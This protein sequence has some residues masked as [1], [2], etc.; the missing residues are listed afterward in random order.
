MNIILQTALRTTI[1]AALLTGGALF[2]Q[3]SQSNAPAPDNTK[4]N[5]RDRDS[6]QPTADQQKMNPSIAKPRNRSGSRLRKTNR[7]PP[8]ATT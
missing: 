7:F 2:A 5:Q 8:T 6:S 1:C 4:I 3:D